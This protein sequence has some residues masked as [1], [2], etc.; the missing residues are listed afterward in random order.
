M[1]AFDYNDMQEMQQ[2]TLMLENERRQL[3]QEFQRQILELESKYKVEHEKWVNKG[4]FDGNHFN[5]A[6]LIGKQ[7]LI[8]RKQLEHLHSHI[9]AVEKNRTGDNHG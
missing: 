8:K 5:S 2:H 9:N 3:T 4:N 7:L 1:D 6:S